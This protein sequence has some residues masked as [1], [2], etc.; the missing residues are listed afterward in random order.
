VNSS[1]LVRRNILADVGPFNVDKALHGTEDYE[2][3][4][5]IAYAHKLVSIAEPLIR[6]RVHRGSLAGN[7]AKA[8][9]RGIL[10]LRGRSWS[11][12][13]ARASVLLPMFWQCCKFTIYTLAR[14]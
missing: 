9:L 8:T 13:E 11:R 3:W 5:R 4:L 12:A 6:Y 1:V 10:V 7:R 2:M 14:R